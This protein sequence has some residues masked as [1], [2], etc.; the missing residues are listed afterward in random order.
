VREMYKASDTSS[1]LLVGNR[2]IFK[3]VCL[4]SFKWII[5]YV[6]INGLSKYVQKPEKIDFKYIEI[7]AIVFNKL[8]IRAVTEKG[9]NTRYYGKNQIFRWF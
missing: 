3:V 7:N 6:H 8:G 1:F 2:L 4:C 9:R 5:K